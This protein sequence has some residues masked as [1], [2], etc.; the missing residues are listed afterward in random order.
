MTLVEEPKIIDRSSTVEKF[1]SDDNRAMELARELCRTNLKFLC[2]RMLKYSDWDRCHDEMV[3]WLEGELKKPC[4]KKRIIFMLLPRGHLKTSIITIGKSIQEMLKNPDIRILLTNAVW[5][6]AR[7]FLSEITAFLTTKSHLPSL[8][9]AFQN[10]KGFNQDAI[11]IRQ[12]NRPN[13]TPTISTS[14][15]DSARAS[16]H[17][18]WV[19]ADDIV[20]RQN[21]SSPELR[22]KTLLYYKDMMDLL[23]PTGT[24][25]IIGTRWHDG[26]LYGEKLREHGIKK[27]ESE[28]HGYSSVFDA[29]ISFYVR[30]VEIDSKFI[31]PKK[32][33]NNIMAQIAREKGSFETSAQYYNDPISSED[34]QFK[35]PVRYWSEIGEGTVHYGAFDPATSEKKNSCDAVVLSGAL[36]RGN[37]L[38]AVEY[39]AF[40]KKDPTLMFDKIFEY[41]QKYGWRKFALEVNGGQEVYVK[42]LQEEQ[43]KRN[44]FFEIVPLHH[45]KDKFSRIIALQPRHESGNLLLKQGMIELEDQMLR[46]PVSS[47][48]D[49][50]DAFAMIQEIAVPMM[51]KPK[52]Y[53][54]KEYA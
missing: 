17:Y 45:I 46:F 26:D 31:F 8:F 22:E 13:K 41:A 29:A 27:L 51:Q 49:I 21:V 34:Q 11:T 14:G 52:V 23:E 24:L 1:L 3:D 44:V 20:N 40:D 54:P 50:V 9:G 33:N 4:D 16:Q 47:K 48:L 5:D 30:K 12:R 15:V 42:L 6:M 28:I 25:I 2:Q 19:V 10:D 39:K 37:Q 7:S 32:F 36:N 18:D 38:L 53:V 43:R 35:P